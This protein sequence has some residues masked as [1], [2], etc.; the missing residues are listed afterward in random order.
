[1]MLG[2]GR[3]CKRSVLVCLFVCLFNTKHSE[4][5]VFFPVKLAALTAV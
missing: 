1:M 3:V 2:R 5:F 4:R